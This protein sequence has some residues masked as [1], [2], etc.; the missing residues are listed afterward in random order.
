MLK[1]DLSLKVLSY[2]ANSSYYESKQITV[3][4]DL[5]TALQDQDALIFKMSDIPSF[6]SKL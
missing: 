5:T 4:L 3:S 1:R 6:E 2:V